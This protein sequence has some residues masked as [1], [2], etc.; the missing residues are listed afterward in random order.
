MQSWLKNGFYGYWFSPGMMLNSRC[1]IEGLAVKAM[2][3]SGDISQDQVELLKRQFFLIEYNC[4][5]K[6]SDIS[7]EFLFP[8]KLKGDWEQA[9]SYYKDKL[10][11]KFTGQKILK[12]IGSGNPFLCDEKLNY[13]KIIE[14]YLGEEYAIC[15]GIL[16]QCSHPSD[17]TL[18]NNEHLFPLLLSVYDLIKKCYGNLPKSKF[19]LTAYTNM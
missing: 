2:Y 8:D 5:K 6:F 17:N 1:I 9:C 3:E 16:S 15:Y 10:K 19:T 4:Y 13:H 12:I 18:S 14:T 7:Q 11:D